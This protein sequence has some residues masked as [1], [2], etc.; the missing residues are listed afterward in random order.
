MLKLIPKV[1]AGSL[2]KV[3]L[4]PEVIAIG[5][6]SIVAPL[7]EP[8]ISKLIDSIPF[9]RKH[10]RMALITFSIVIL[11]ISAKMKA[12][13]FRAIVIGVAGANFFIAIIPTMRTLM[14]R[15]N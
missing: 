1:S 2:G 6:A 12:G 8:H 13:V 14:N 5:S 7:L 10:A 4:S 3:L 11:L 9:A 15:R